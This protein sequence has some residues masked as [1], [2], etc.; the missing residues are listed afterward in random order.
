[1]KKANAKA[2][3]AAASGSSDSCFVGKRFRKRV[4]VDKETFR[5]AV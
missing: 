5:N 3:E 4:K 1:M 2:Q